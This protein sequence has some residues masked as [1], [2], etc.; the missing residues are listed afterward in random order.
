MS[1]F[2]FSF[3]F[4]SEGSIPMESVLAII[5]DTNLSC[6]ITISLPRISMATILFS[7]AVQFEQ[8][9]YHVLQRTF[10]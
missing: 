8:L 2:L 10:P 9:K 5:T 7:G 6:F 3:I 1:L 4:S